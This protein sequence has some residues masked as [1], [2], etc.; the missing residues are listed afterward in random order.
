MSVVYWK[1]QDG[2][3]HVASQLG[4]NESTWCGRYDDGD[5]FGGSLERTVPS[6]GPAT[7]ADCREAI[8]DARES[9]RGIRWTRG[10]LR[11]TAEED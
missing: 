2:I 9:L 4:D 10:R 3:V 8:D 1:D 7:C 6:A 5:R 11:R